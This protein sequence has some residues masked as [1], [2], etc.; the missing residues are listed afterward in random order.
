MFLKP[1][2]QINFGPKFIIFS[3]PYRIIA[4]STD[5]RTLIATILPKCGLLNSAN[6]IHNVRKCEGVL[7]LAN[8][9]SVITDYLCRQSMGGAN[10]HSYILKQIAVVPPSHVDLACPWDATALSL[11][12][13]C[14]PRILD[15][16]H[17]GCGNDSHK[18]RQKVRPKSSLVVLVPAPE[19]TYL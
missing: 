14:L 5:E 16:T 19:H 10:L 12:N 4:R 17:T 9:N 1:R 11:S 3:L 6:N 8:L 15:L 13:W 18:I 7:L 2:S